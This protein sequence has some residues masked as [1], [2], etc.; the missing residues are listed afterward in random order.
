MSQPTVSV[1]IT[2]YNRPDYLQAALNS[3]L[4]Q[5]YGNYEIIV[6]DDCSET[7]LSGVIE[8]PPGGIRYVRQSENA[9][10]SAARNRGVALAKGDYVAFLDDDDQWLPNKL[11]LQVAAMDGHEACLCG[12][13]FLERDRNQVHPIAT[14]TADLLRRGN[15]F[16]GASGFMARRDALMAC[17]FDGDLSSGEEW[18]VYV[19]ISQRGSIAYVPEPLFLYRLGAHQSITTQARA[20]N[21]PDIGV[22][23][24]HIHKNRAW[25][26][27]T[28]YRILLAR[29][30]L[31]YIGA[32]PNKTRFLFYAIRHAG[33]GATLD[34]LWK[35]TFQSRDGLV[36]KE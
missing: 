23:I 12:F 7:D 34:A 8:P 18:D 28:H 19:R 1:V 33:W 21:I 32:K 13:T 11:D 30:I 31:E 26:G 29:K 20:M 6:V 15:I 16:C 2:A 10:P 27:E 9:G 14:V 17:P 25:L 36:T 5:T 35:K 22:R 3:A 4:G 24:A